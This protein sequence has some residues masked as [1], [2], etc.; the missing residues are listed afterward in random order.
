MK[1][2][3]FLKEGIGLKKHFLLI[4]IIALFVFSMIQINSDTT[5]SAH[6]VNYH[7][8]HQNWNYRQLVTINKSI[9]S[10]GLYN[11]P[12]LIRNDG[13]IGVRD[14]ANYNGEDFLF[15]NYYDNSTVYPH[16]YEFNNDLDMTGN[17]L[18]WVKIPYLNPNQDTKIWMYYGNLI[19][20]KEESGLETTENENAVWD[21]TYIGVYHMETGG[22]ST[23]VDATNNHNNGT[24]YGGTGS[25]VGKIGFGTSFDGTGDYFSIPDSMALHDFTYQITVEAWLYDTASGWQSFMGK[26]T[27]AKDLYCY[28]NGIYFG[29]CARGQR[30]SDYT[31]TGK[32]NTLNQWYYYAMTLDGANIKIYMNASLSGSTSVT[33]KRLQLE[34]NTSPLTIGRHSAYTSEDFTGRLDEIRISNVARN[35]TWLLTNYR[36]ARNYSSYETFGSEQ[37]GGY[38][39]PNPTGLFVDSISSSVLKLNWTSGI[40]DEEGI[41]DTY[42]VFMNNTWYP[43]HNGVVVYNDTGTDFLYSNLTYETQYFFSVWSW[44]DSNGGCFSNISSNDHAVTLGLSLIDV[45]INSSDCNVSYNVSFGYMGNNVEYEDAVSNDL[46]SN[47]QDGDWDTWADMTFTTG[48]IY[49]YKPSMFTYGI[50]TVKEGYFGEYEYEVTEDDYNFWDNDTQICF[51]ITAD[52]DGMYYYIYNPDTTDSELLFTSYNA[53]LYEEKL[54]WL[55]QSYGYIINISA[56]GNTTTCDSTNLTIYN[57]TA[58]TTGYYESQY[59]PLMGWYLWMNYTGELPLFNHYENIINA[60]GTHQHNTANDG[61]TINVWANY[62]GNL[63][64]L[65]YYASNITMSL[66]NCTGNYSLVYSNITT[67]LYLDETSTMLTGNCSDDDWDTSDAI[68]TDYYQYTTYNKSSIT[69]DVDYWSIRDGE[70]YHNFTITNAFMNLD[71][72]SIINVSIVHDSMLDINFYGI[73]YEMMPGMWSYFNLYTSGMGCQNKIYEQGMVIGNITVSSSLQLLF[74]ATGNTTP[75]IHLQNIINAT[76]NFTHSLRIDGYHLWANY[77]GNTTP[78]TLYQNPLY[79]SG[80]H[81]KTLR[82]VGGWDVYANYSSAIGT[83]ENIVNASGTHEYVWNGSTN[84]WW[85]WANYT[86]TGGGAPTPISLFQSFVNATG[87]HQFVLTGAGYQVWANVTGNVSSAVNITSYIPIDGNGVYK[88][89]LLVGMLVALPMVLMT[90]R[91]RRRRMQ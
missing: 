75:L 81:T 1:K 16:D 24:E 18:C 11:Y 60:T 10:I 69:A 61:Y 31:P 86:G 70:G 78:V 39:T 80:T 35:A 90:K 82:G 87:T 91:K 66:V 19:D 4:G 20:Y 46:P 62:T 40:E 36:F 84:K 5:V 7:W 51:M 2:K 44:N 50:W 52:M 55:S 38:Y 73:W 53:V 63:T 72:T 59:N 33:Y 32:W 47:C 13:N 77:T 22:A 30:D 14:N 89:P 8:Y 49:Y 71:T 74:N 65:S 48:Y 79:A 54:S 83:S 76:G 68:P 23:L 41:T 85:V 21:E 29:G 56:T 57:N 28:N 3:S 9:T 12:V 88:M 26:S 45:N 37:R 6:D 64:S 15:V 43:H 67:P 25:E 27:H 58:H 17:V 34:N 42:V